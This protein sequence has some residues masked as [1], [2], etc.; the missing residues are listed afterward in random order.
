MKHLASIG[1]ITF[2]SSSIY[3]KKIQ[4]RWLFWSQTSWAFYDRPMSKIYRSNTMG[5]N[6][7]AIVHLDLGLV[8]ALTIDYARSKLYWS[9]THFK[10]I[11]SS[12]LDGSNRAIV[13]N[14]DVSL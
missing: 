12:N 9:D 3:N 13:L 1:S 6:A 11:E 10:N 8:L 7:T 2:F 14:T 5:N 4:S